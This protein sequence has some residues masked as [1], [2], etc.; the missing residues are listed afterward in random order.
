M[1]SK[2]K[3]DNNFLC[4]IPAR[5]GS[6]GLKNK[7]IKILNGKPLIAWSIITAK[8]SKYLQ[9][10]IVSTD[11]S[12]IANISKKFGA[13]V[14]FLRPKKYAQDKSSSFSVIK[15]ALDFLKTKD[16]LYDYIVL[17]EPTS[18]IRDVSDIDYC[19]KKILRNKL[20]TLVSVSKII[21]Q[22]PSF[23]YFLSKKNFLKP[24]NKKQSNKNVRRQDIS[25]LYYL[26]GSLYI[27]KVSSYLKNKTF[28]HKKTQAFIVDQRKSLEIDSIYDFKLAQ[29]LLRKKK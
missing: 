15:H 14:P 3:I 1:I 8:K 16:I 25:S 22:H 10:I 20:D 17:L 13:E 2:N 26:D 28:N 11:C 19:I 24:Y 27:S 12:K 18:P 7:N 5:K 4:I 21:N 6:K 23:L 9:N 29:L